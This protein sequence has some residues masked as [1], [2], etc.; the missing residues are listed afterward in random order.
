MPS[1]HEH[2]FI[3]Q[4]AALVLAVCVSFAV[5]ALH[6]PSQQNQF[7]LW[8]DD[9]NVYQNPHIK[10]FDLQFIFWAFTDMTSGNWQPL[11]WIS[12]A[13]NYSVGGVN[14]RGYHITNIILHSV[15]T[16]LVV[17][18]T[19]TLLD[20]RRGHARTGIDSPSGRVGE[21]SSL[22]FASGVSGL[23]FGC[24]PLRVESVSWISGRTDLLCALF[25]LMSVIAYSDYARG[26]NDAPFPKEGAYFARRSYLFSFVFFLLA[27]FSKPMAVTLPAVLLLLDWHPLGRITTWK[28]FVNLC[29]EKLPYLMVSVLLTLLTYSAETKLAAITSFADV[30]LSARLLVAVKATA[31]YVVKMIWPF[32]LAPFY[33]YPKDPALRSVEYVSAI[34]LVACGALVSIMLLK[35][36]KLVLFGWAYYVITLLPVLGLIKAR[37]VYMADRY[38]YLP[39]VGL[40]LISGIFAAFLWNRARKAKSNI[41]IIAVAALSILTLTYYSYLTVRQNAIWKDSLTLWNYV[42]D[43]EGIHVTEAYN[44][45]GS[46]YGE[47]GNFDRA[48]KDFAGAIA[49]NP[50]D[51]AAYGN[52]AVALEC[53]GSFERALEYYNAAILL[54]PAGYLIYFNRGILRGKMGDLPGAIHDYSKTLLLKA[55]F[56]AARMERANAY[57]E[58]GR[59]DLAL[60]EYQEECIRGSEDACNAMMLYQPR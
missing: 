55:D 12:H 24:H 3:K 23:L 7:V 28:N 15:N 33:P 42:I 27:A 21:M 35:K 1:V 2:T 31:S 17:W 34:I 44:N 26:K 14:P 18:L 53:K 60:K 4:R 50:S 46:F 5:F 20:I 45:R 6:L 32:H 58:T 9:L 30:P 38:S 22:L 11:T 57:R 52:M 51:A 41:L 10:N 37:P 16:F 59:N 39:S 29:V 54:N 47:Q 43:E 49:V 25:Y 19:F 40:C 36:R 8:D 13:L 56:T 48:I